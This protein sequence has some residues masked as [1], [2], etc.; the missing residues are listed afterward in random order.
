MNSVYVAWK[1]L[2]CGKGRRKKERKKETK[3]EKG[4]RGGKREKITKLR[5]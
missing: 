4:E 3:K 2:R 5:W 1:T